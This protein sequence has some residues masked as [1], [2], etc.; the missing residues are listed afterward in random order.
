MLILRPFRNWLT[1]IAS[2]NVYVL[3]IMCSFYGFGYEKESKGG[4]QSDLAA[5]PTT[6]NMSQGLN[7]NSKLQDPT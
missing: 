7:I 1:D 2:L 4:K 6:S 3:C 5:W